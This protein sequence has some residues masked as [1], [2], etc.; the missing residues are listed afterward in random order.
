MTGF[1]AGARQPQIT[2]LLSHNHSLCYDQADN[3][4]NAD[5]QVNTGYAIHTR[6]FLFTPHETW[7]NLLYFDFPIN[8]TSTTE[9]KTLILC[10]RCVSRNRTQKRDVSIKCDILMH[11]KPFDDNKRISSAC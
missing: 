6:H 10:S 8:K 4:V 7:R 2:D 3:S 1:H 11:E 9:S 5:T